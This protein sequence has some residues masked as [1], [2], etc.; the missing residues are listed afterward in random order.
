MKEVPI[1]RLDT[2]TDEQRRAYALV[3]NQ[4][5][6]NTGFDDEKLKIE[7]RDISFD[8]SCF[9]FDDNESD[10]STIEEPGEIIEDEIP[11]LPDEPKS[12]YGDVYFLGDHKLMCGDATKIEDLEKLMDC[13]KR[14]WY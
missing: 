4:L 14:I 8:M 5:T 10:D 7:L 9:G 6:M 11:E 3:H 2:L 1:I 12:K 13:E